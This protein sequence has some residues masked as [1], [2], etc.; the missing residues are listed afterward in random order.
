MSDRF[1]LRIVDEF[2]LLLQPVSL[3]PLPNLLLLQP[4]NDDAGGDSKVAREL[5]DVGIRA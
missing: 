2:E 3:V 5:G 4:T 1:V